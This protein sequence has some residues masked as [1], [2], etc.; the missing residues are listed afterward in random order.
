M[1]MQKL[2]FKKDK[3]TISGQSMS[4]GRR[5]GDMGETKFCINIWILQVWMLSK[6]AVH[7]VKMFELKFGSKFNCE[8]PGN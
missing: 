4:K 8:L 7:I 5:G 6:S 1:W 2:I 3:V